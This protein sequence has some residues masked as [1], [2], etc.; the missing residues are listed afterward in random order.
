MNDLQPE[1]M[2]RAQLPGYANKSDPEHRQQSKNICWD[3]LFCP[4]TYGAQTSEK[5]KCNYS[6]PAYL[7]DVSRVGVHFANL[8]F[9]PK[10]AALV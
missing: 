9:H 7:P 1:G 3:W 4:E 6:E 8:P 2:N 5:E 10:Q